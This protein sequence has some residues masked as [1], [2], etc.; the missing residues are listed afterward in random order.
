MIWLHKAIYPHLSL[1]SYY[2]KMESETIRNLCKACDLNIIIAIRIT[3]ILVVNHRVLHGT[4][5]WGG[6]IND[7]NV[8][9]SQKHC[10]Q[11]SKIRQETISQNQPFQTTGKSFHSFLSNNRFHFQSIA[12][13]LII[14]K[15]Q[16]TEI[17]RE[18]NYW[19][20]RSDE[21]LT[22]AQ[23][24]KRRRRRVSKAVRTDDGGSVIGLPGV[25][26]LTEQ[27]L[28]NPASA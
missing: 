14:Q 7:F 19:G 25:V 1:K 22:E 15:V 12:A 13:F 17:E 8:D 6:K 5:Y 16:I 11:N 28:Q 21:E 18:K 24:E 3:T 23:I 4:K 20:L 27:A 26:L 9:V 10:E 2:L